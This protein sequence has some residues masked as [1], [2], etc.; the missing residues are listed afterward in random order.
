MNV[1]K[2]VLIS[3]YCCIRITAHGQTCPYVQYTYDNAGNRI[4]RTI[5]PC[6]E[7]GDPTGKWGGVTK[8]IDTT[9]ISNV[10]ST[11]SQVELQL[12]PNP[13]DGK[14]LLVFNTNLTNATITISN[15][16]GQ[17]V[18]QAHTSGQEFPLDLTGYASGVYFV[19]VQIPKQNF[20]QQ[21]VKQ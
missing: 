6:G 14:F 12:Y 21:V 4:L 1:F 19:T 20:Q 2:F 9:G 7:G 16:I 8:P 13:T 5:V 3:V 15:N 17:R 18:Y 10:D 11:I